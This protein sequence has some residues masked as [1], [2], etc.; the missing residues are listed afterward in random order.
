L[1]GLGRYRSDG[2]HGCRIIMVTDNW[3]LQLSHR[4]VGNTPNS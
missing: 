2:H 1:G 4:V 3:A